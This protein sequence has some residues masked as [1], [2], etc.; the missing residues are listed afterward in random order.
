MGLIFLL[1]VI[2]PPCYD[3]HVFINLFQ[4][5]S[6]TRKCYYFFLGI[7]RVPPHWCLISSSLAD[8]RPPPDILTAPQALTSPALR[9]SHQRVKHSQ[10]SPT[11]S[12]IDD[13]LGTPGCS[14]I[15][16]LRCVQSDSCQG[17]AVGLVNRKQSLL[18]SMSPV[19]L[20]K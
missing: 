12:Y 10:V 2:I 14:S 8:P 16:D 17:A 9:V 13:P 1:S 6:K 4:T 11:L 3:E 7:S 19:L 5:C 15:R 18:R 20:R